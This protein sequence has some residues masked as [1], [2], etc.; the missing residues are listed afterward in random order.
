MTLMH[1]RARIMMSAV[2]VVVLGCAL[3]SRGQ[4]QT[5]LFPVENDR[6]SGYID[7]TGQIII[8]LQFD[9]ASDF[10]EGLALVTTGRERSFID[11]SGQVVF[12]ASFDIVENFS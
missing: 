7:R 8:P 10:H 11:I 4:Q 3:N 2:I 1:I 12:K 6:K 5:T 9:T